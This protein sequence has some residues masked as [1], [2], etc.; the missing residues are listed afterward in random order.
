MTAYESWELGRVGR[1][2]SSRQVGLGGPDAGA[3]ARHL[4]LGRPGLTLG[5]PEVGFGRAVRGL[6]VIQLL[7]ADYPVSDRRRMRSTSWSVRLGSSA[8][9][10][11]MPAWAAPLLAEAC[12]TWAVASPFRPPPPLPRS[13][14]ASAS[15]TRTW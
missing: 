1:G 13:G 11:P 7:A 5:G 9:A 2:L 8:W 4:R 14:S 12:P 10:E 15:C 6:R 3:R